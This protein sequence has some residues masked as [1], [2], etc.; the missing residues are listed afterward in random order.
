[1]YLT[2]CYCRYFVIVLVLEM[3]KKLQNAEDY[4]DGR[5]K[6]VIERSGPL[7]ST[8]VPVSASTSASGPAPVESATMK[9]VVEMDTGITATF[10][11]YRENREKTAIFWFLSVVTC[12]LFY[13]VA[14]WNLRFRLRCTMDRCRISEAQWI[15]ASNDEGAEDLR[16]VERTAVNGGEKRLKFFTYRYVRFIYDLSLGKYIICDVIDMIRNDFPTQG[17]NDKIVRDRRNLVGEN[18]YE[19]E[20]KP[21]Y[22]ILL[23][24]IL[25]P[26]NVFQIFA[27]F[28]WF[29][30]E[31]EAYALAIIIMSVTGIVSTFRETLKSHRHLREMAYFSCPVNILRNGQWIQGVQSEDL[32]PGDIFEVDCDMEILPCDAL[33]ISGEVLLN[34]S[35]LTGESIP[36]VRKSIPADE[37]LSDNLDNK[38]SI[39]YS[40]TR[41]MR[42]R[43]GNSR[44]ALAMVI[45]TGFDTFKGFL[46]RQIIFPPPLKFKFYEDSIKYILFLSCLAFGGL[47]YTLYCSIIRHKS[48]AFEVFMNC[49]DLVT[50]VVP[51]ALPAILVI[52]TSAAISRLKRNKM[53]T[54]FPAK[55]NI[56][57]RLDVFCFDKTGTL[58]EEGLDICAVVGTKIPDVDSESSS[59]SD[60]SSEGSEDAGTHQS[61]TTNFKTPAYEPPGDSSECSDTEPGEIRVFSDPVTDPMD[62][63]DK[64]F[65]LLSC[66]HTVTVVHG[67]MVGDPLDLK[68]FEF[69]GCVLEEPDHSPDDQNLAGTTIRPFEGSGNELKII[70]SF[71]FDA[72]LKR[73]SVL[74]KDV[75]EDSFEFYTKGA[76]EVIKEHCRPE[77]LPEDFDDLLG[78]YAR[79]GQRVVACAYRRVPDEVEELMRMP[80]A[81][82][83]MELHFLG[84]IVFENKLK[85]ESPVAISELAAAQ[86]RS[87]MVTGDNV[88]TA[89]NVARKC[90]IVD[91]D[92]KVFF[93]VN[94]QVGPR[95]EVKFVNVEDSSEWLTD[96]P[97]FLLHHKPRFGK[98][99]NVQVALTGRVFSQLK[100]LYSWPLFSALLSRCNI[101]SRMSPLEK[102]ELVEELQELEHCVAMVGDG[103]NDC[104]ALRVADV[105]ISLSETEAS[106]AA[107]FCSAV[108][109]IACAP[110][111]VREGRCALATSFASFKYMTL[112]SAVQFTTVCLLR[113][114]NVNL[115]A[116]QF[117]CF[118]MITVL[119]LGATLTASGPRTKLDPQRPTASLLSAPVLASILCQVAVIIGFQVLVR[120]WIPISKLVPHGNV[121]LDENKQILVGLAYNQILVPY[122]AYQ[123]IW[124]AVI[125]SF[126]GKYRERVVKN[127]RFI[128]S[129]SFLVL[130]HTA[131]LFGWLLELTE[132]VGF[133][134]LNNMVKGYFRYKREENKI[135]FVYG[136]PKGNVPH[137]IISLAFIN[138]L[139]CL[140][141]EFLLVPM[142]VSMV[143]AFKRRRLTAREQLEAISIDD[144]EKSDLPV[145]KNINKKPILKKL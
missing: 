42:V 20:S 53:T 126:G 97:S 7:D 83:E 107:P 72:T 90:G 26:F 39:L 85:D 45:R 144:L 29:S 68:M 16:K 91:E 94:D 137:K 124:T 140:A 96:L 138:L 66:C 55:I 123:Y 63:N 48:S 75:I 6:E 62:L 34:E 41:L 101:Y 110:Q 119:L 87:V 105:G 113:W 128:L 102:H 12:G 37:K 122:S 65:H 103:A 33:L 8:E 141:V 74:I 93:P 118:D 60:S 58:T 99:P 22:L 24:G 71:P 30:Q 117:I 4:D 14:L 43:G 40:G 64:F 70:R 120:M 106:L 88:L 27:S 111:L 57:G 21:M 104:G 44:R 89:V 125:Y 143:K 127:W 139:I 132:L 28:V 114:F 10:E 11:G 23:D 47:L 82:I 59:D 135:Y 61:T 2:I 52:S 121:E 98:V 54:T 78:Y 134:Y 116:Y 133:E 142:I 80:R 5:V 81:Q 145:R 19:V 69:T 86:I 67:R 15:Y 79:H 1:M 13:A 3:T 49:C 100:E 18:S 131:L 38:A 115:S 32:V 36:V 109:T 92:C 46:I 17:L 130:L 73:Q 136:P 84:F 51:P 112:Y 25:H 95:G 76:P 77:T 56:C 31:Q 9:Q 108:P 50:V 35:M 129:V